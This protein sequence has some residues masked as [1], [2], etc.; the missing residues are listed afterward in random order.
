VGRSADICG[1]FTVRRSRGS[2]GG[3]GRGPSMGRFLSIRNAPTFRRQAQDWDLH[4]DSSTTRW[5]CRRVRF[6]SR[7][8]LG[9]AALLPDSIGSKNVQ[10]Q[11]ADLLMRTRGAPGQAPTTVLVRQ[12][13]QVIEPPNRLAAREAHS[14]DR[15]NQPSQADPPLVGRT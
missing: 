8:A 4:P 5:N 12:Q 9:V 11:S 1:Y 10:Q 13:H 14:R 3:L 2:R 7:M 15:T 6:M